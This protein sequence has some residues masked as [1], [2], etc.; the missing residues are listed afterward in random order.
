MLDESLR[1]RLEA[2]NRGPLPTQVSPRPRR[3]TPQ[4][5]R[6][7][8][9]PRAVKPLPGLL[10]RAEVVTNAA[11]EHLRVRLPL[12]ELWRR[13]PELVAAR[14]E[15]L[16]QEDAGNGD[17]LAAVIRA[18]PDRLLLVDLETCGLAGAALFLIGVLRS[19][20]DVL[21]LELLLARNY[22]QERAILVSFWQI[23]AGRDVLVTFNGKA[24]DWP[25]MLDRSRRH[26]LIRSQSRLPAPSLQSP[27]SGLPSPLRHVDLLHHA[28]R[29]WKGELPDCRLQTLERH[30]CRRRRVG[31]VPGHMIPAAYADFVRTGIPREMESVLYHNAL[32]L[33]TLLDLAMRL[34]G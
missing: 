32:D 23:A 11:G 1:R 18:F 33:V 25:M 27:A 24:F 16:A 9:E 2:L 19:I 34:A 15:Q 26:L 3:A 5:K 29:R 4:T 14:R 21:T 30:V 20:S 6:A 10:R 28:R 22:S 17:E 7:I 8:V 31:D 13:G 12:A